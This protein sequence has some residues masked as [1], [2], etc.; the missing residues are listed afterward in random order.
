M[1]PTNKFKQI[2]EKGETIT[3][4]ATVSAIGEDGVELDYDTIEVLPSVM[5]AEEPKNMGESLKRFMKDKKD[6]PMADDGEE[7][8]DQ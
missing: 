8:M 3:I 7:E 1:I 4:R 5:E 2:P 6:A